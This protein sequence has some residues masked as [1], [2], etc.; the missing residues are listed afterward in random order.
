MPP[1]DFEIPDDDSTDGTESAS[2]SKASPAFD[3]EQ[4]DHR[5]DLHS[6]V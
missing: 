5:S 2:Q 3:L 1:E 4:W 6:F